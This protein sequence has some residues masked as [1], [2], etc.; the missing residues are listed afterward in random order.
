MKKQ[1]KAIYDQCSASENK[2]VESSGDEI[3]VESE[4]YYGQRRGPWRR[5]SFHGYTRHHGFNVRNRNTGGSFSP[6]Q[7]GRFVP[8]EDNRNP[9]G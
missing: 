2:K 6:N 5:G 4:V 8:R 3:Q 1:I 7:A 9:I